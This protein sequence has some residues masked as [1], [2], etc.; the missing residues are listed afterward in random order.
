MPFK[1]LDQRRRYNR[2]QAQKQRV[3]PE[4]RAAHAAKVREWR[5]AHPDATRAQDAAWRARNPEKLRAKEQRRKED[6]AQHAKQLIRAA[7]YQREY[8]AAHPREVVSSKLKSSYGIALEQYEELE[9]MQGGC[10]AICGRKEP[11]VRNGKPVRW[12]V[13]HDHSKKQVRGLLCTNCNQGIGRFKDDP[14]LLLR[15]A[16]YLTNPPARTVTTAC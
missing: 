11:Q 3:T 2:E 10:C 16:S 7:K 9:R 15:A 5:A 8:A 4:G 13:D 14:A 1:D 12:R 6:P